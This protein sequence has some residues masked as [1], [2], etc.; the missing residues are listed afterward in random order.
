MNLLI[1]S[2]HFYHLAA[3]EITLLFYYIDN[4][5]IINIEAYFYTVL[6]FIDKYAIV[7]CCVYIYYIF[8]LKHI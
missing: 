4:K 8:I 7:Q 3:K 5:L 1:V 6:T 2:R